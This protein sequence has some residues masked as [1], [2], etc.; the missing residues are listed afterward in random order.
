MKRI[1]V[2]MAALALMASGAL[3]DRSINWGHDLGIFGLGGTGIDNPG[4]T[5]PTGWAVVMFQDGG[6]NT[7]SGFERDPFAGGTTASLGDDM[8]AQDSTGSGLQI[9]VQYGYDDSGTPNV[10]PYL[11]LYFGDT[12][13]VVPGQSVFTVVF[14]NA[15]I[16][17]AT[18]YLIVDDSLYTTPAGGPSDQPVDYNAGSGSAGEWMAITPEPSSVAL[19]ALGLVAL[20]ARVRRKK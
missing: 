5:D 14:N 9:A 6:D 12:I 20:V 2:T 13:N 18:H 1:V 3:A 4:T 10:A 17:A 19:M 15:D 8:I 11:H 7:M 16:N